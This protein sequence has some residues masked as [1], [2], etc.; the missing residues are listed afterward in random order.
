MED[1]R[2]I[3]IILSVLFVIIFGGLARTN[4]KLTDIN[5]TLSAIAAHM[6]VAN[7]K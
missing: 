4:N 7:E 5:K 3:A 6:Q 2:F 1:I